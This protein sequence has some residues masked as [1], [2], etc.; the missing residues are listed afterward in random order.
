MEF[1]IF[2]EYQNQNSDA[3][4]I[5]SETIHWPWSKVTLLLVRLRTLYLHWQ[6]FGICTTLKSQQIPFDLLICTETSV[7]TS[8]PNHWR[9]FPQEHLA[10]CHD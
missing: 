10:L 1:Q 4:V 9:N 7:L 6:L 8:D 5:T 2:P 3:W